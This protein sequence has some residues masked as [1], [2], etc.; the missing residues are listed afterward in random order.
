MVQ[1]PL[2]SCGTE[3]TIK[4]I[5]KECPNTKFEGGTEK[6]HGPKAEAVNWLNSPKTP[7]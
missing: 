4:H 2:C 1:S 6:L 5:V 7:L 3:Q